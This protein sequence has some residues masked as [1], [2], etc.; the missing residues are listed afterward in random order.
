[1]VHKA[2]DFKEPHDLLGLFSRQLNLLRA[3]NFFELVECEDV[4][5]VFQQPLDASSNRLSTGFGESSPTVMAKH[6][7]PAAACS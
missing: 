4:L 5:L 1:V 7:R 6:L 2:R 3:G